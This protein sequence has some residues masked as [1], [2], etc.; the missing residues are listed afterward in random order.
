[1]GLAQRMGRAL[2][3]TVTKASPKVALEAVSEWNRL[4]LRGDI[5]RAR[6]RI[7]LEFLKNRNLAELIYK[8]H[9]EDMGPDVRAIFEELMGEKSA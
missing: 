8:K 4:V 1:M 9:H 7:K 3:D 5:E 6:A 2:L